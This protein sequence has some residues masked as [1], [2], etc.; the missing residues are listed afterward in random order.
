MECISSDIVSNN[1]GSYGFWKFVNSKCPIGVVE[2]FNW[3]N[4]TELADIFIAHTYLP[5]I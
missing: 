2:L 5:S 3:T 4:A 1:G